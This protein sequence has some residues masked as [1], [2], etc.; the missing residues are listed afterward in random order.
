MNES[1]LE[2]LENSLYCCGELL[3][4]IQQDSKDLDENSPDFELCSKLIVEAIKALKFVMAINN[5]MLEK[6]KICPFKS[7]LAL[8]ENA[9]A[10]SLLN[11][12]EEIKEKSKKQ[13]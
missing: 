1:E 2:S 6:E 4:F 3:E 13:P 7:R 12:M 5:E 9:K 8:S 10:K 11:S